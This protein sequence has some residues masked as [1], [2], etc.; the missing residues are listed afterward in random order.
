MSKG[1][2]PDLISP[3]DDADGRCPECGDLFCSEQLSLGSDRN[4][5]CCDCRQDRQCRACYPDSNEE[6][7]DDE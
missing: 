5:T 1:P 4:D 3:P 7:N 2:Y 6:L